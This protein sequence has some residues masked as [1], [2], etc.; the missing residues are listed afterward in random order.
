MARVSLPD[1]ATQGGL[2]LL[3]SSSV[4][5][6]SNTFLSNRPVLLISKSCLN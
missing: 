1:L 6:S 4:G 5:G 2:S 3:V